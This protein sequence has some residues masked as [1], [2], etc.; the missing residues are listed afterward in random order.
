[1]KH[2]NIDFTKLLKDYKSDWVA[3]S[4]DFK[5][6]KYSGETLKEVREKAKNTK[7]KLYFFPAEQSYANYISN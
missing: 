4:S 3:I 2:T 6:V 7:D 5:S 1:M